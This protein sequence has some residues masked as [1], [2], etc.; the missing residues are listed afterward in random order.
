MKPLPEMVGRRRGPL[1]SRADMLVIRVVA[2]LAGQLS[3]PAV[4]AVGALLAL[5]RGMPFVAGLALAALL[6]KPQLIWLLPVGLVLAAQWRVLA[7]FACGAALWLV[8]A[9]ALV[10]A[11]QLARWPGEVAARAPAIRSS[12]GMPG[13]LVML[14]G[15]GVGAGAFLVC[16]AA[17]IALLWRFRARAATPPDRRG[18]LPGALLPCRAAHL[19]LRPRATCRATPDRWRAP[20]RR[21]HRVRGVAQRCVSVRSLRA[22]L[23]GTARNRGG[24]GAG[25]GDSFTVAAGPTQS[26]GDA[27]PPTAR[28]GCDSRRLISLRAMKGCVNGPNRGGKPASS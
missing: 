27:R 5:D 1:V 20:S 3:R 19:R 24:G 8:S 9:L 18:A 22:V 15:D 23:G 6:M 7:G 26:D 13:L 21:R 11:G 16:A 28:D 10:G 2:R 25:A 12:I 4:A 17:A 14:G